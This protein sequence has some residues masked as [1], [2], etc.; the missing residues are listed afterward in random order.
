MGKGI[1]L[2][3]AQKM[4]KGEPSSREAMIKKKEED[5]EPTFSET[6]E[7]EDSSDDLSV[8]ADELI[9]AIHDKDT[10]GVVEA[11][12]ALHSQMCEDE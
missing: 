8:L 5:D 6:M 9:T 12:K 7:E 1:A 4:K 11:L 2:L 10:S 3:I